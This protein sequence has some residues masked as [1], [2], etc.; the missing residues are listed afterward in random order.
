MTD[1]PSAVDAAASI[2]AGELT[3]ERL[4]RAC[5]ERI[6]AREAE[7]GAWEHLDPELALVQARRRDAEPARGPLHGVPVGVKDIIDTTDLPTGYGSALYRGHR[8]A[9][10]AACVALV[11]MAGGIVLGKTVSTELAYFAPGRTANPAE[12]RH[13]PGGSS[14]GSAA[15][16]ADAMVPVAF[17]TQTAGS[18][19]RPAAFCGVVGYKPSFGLINRSG[20]L[21][22]AES[23]DTVG[24][25]GRTVADAALLASVASGRPALAA[26]EPGPAPR[27]GLWR[28]A[29]WEQAST[30][31]RAA[32]MDA[33]SRLA[34]A[35]AAVAD[36]ELPA[37]FADLSAAHV[38]VMAFEAARAFAHE[39]LVHEPRLS[40]T[41]RALLDQGAACPPRRYDEAVA[42][43]R[44]GREELARVFERHDVLLT[45]SAAGEA[46]VGLG[47]T[48][49]PLFNRTWTLLGT[50]CVHLP[51]FAGPAGLP[52]G[53]QLVGR[54]GDDAGIL[55]AAAW[56]ER[57]LV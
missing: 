16:V 2:A 45:P 51:G 11:R 44:A 43:A 35:G 29:Q 25:F 42:L 32:V 54:A 52:V 27:V 53:V 3:A 28:T 23:L 21:P 33:S 19:I 57:W 24:T 5:L 40:Q 31:A 12:L 38:T 1:L 20:I 7:V 8:P 26:V 48:G 14:S 55:A 6:D 13:T 37:W 15:A 49:D 22:F 46:P 47:S 56:A 4:V 36:A 18:V 39:R 41:L 50:P 10:D 17:G 34:G 9:R 30:A